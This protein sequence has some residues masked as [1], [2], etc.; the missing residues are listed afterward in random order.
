[1][2]KKNYSLGQQFA[3]Q[4]YGDGIVCHVHPFFLGVGFHF[5]S[6]GI[7]GGHKDEQHQDTRYDGVTQIYITE[8]QTITMQKRYIGLEF[9]MRIT[10]RLQFVTAFMDS[11]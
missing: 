4:G 8:N 7:D 5:T 6:N 9:A 10:S 1:M 3:G 11:N 2:T